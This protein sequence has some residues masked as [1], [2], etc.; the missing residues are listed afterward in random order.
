MMCLR[1]NRP[2]AT[3]ALLILLS[4]ASLAGCETLD[5]FIQPGSKDRIKGER[6]AVLSADE[7]VTPDPKLHDKQVVLPQPFV[8]PDWPEPGGYA[9][10]VMHHLSAP[11]QLKEVWSESAGEGSSSDARVTATP[12]IGG[13]KIF[14]L[15][16]SAT[17][18]AFD[19]KT[20]ER[21][22]RV[23][24][25]PE[26]E[27]S[28]K[29]FGGG[30][31][32]DAGKLFVSTG[33]GFVASLDAS[34]GKELWRRNAIVPFRD[35]PVVNGGRVFVATQEN[36]LLALAEDD[37]R[38]LWDHR[39]IAESAGILGSNSVAVAGDVVVVPYTSG[40]LFALRVQNGKPI[41]SDTLS[42]TGRLTPLASL[43]DISGRP[44]I[45]R[46][47]VFANSHAGRLVAIDIRTGERAWTVDVG[48]TQRPWVA[49][50]YVF[51]I[52][53]NARVLC[54]ERADGRI[55][56]V[57]QLDAYGDPE[58]R[59]DPI[60]WAGPVLVSDRLI[61]VSSEGYALSISPYTGEILGKT[62]TPDKAF[63]AP[64]VA[65]NTVYL[66]TDDARL[67]ALK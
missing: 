62:S 14:T 2:R 16:A 31:A 63:I 17:V 50:D 24:L 51:V 53:D 36:Q 33:F 46:G 40:E 60:A 61:A 5:Q 26:D 12:V 9:D 23:D 13:G 65:D 35:A 4:S 58:S 67:T 41:W 47:L 54:L 32:F 19:Q 66:Y 43:S 11:G 64:I 34:S 22:W 45:D 56:W 1:S 37:G 6:V 59:K 10:N 44:V 49:G 8:N 27:D 30:V 28:E 52:T 48:G 25:T 29:G 21:V 42:R 20:G 55:R 18:T 57:T 39:G 15:D 38:I 7:A 3:V